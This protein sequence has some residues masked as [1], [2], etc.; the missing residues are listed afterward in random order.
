M[1]RAS[2]GSIFKTGPQGPVSLVIR[3]PPA[4]CRRAGSA[5]INHSGVCRRPGLKSPV[6]AASSSDPPATATA[7]LEH[8]GVVVRGGFHC[9]TR[10]GLAGDAPYPVDELASY[11]FL[12]SSES[13]PRGVC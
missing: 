2:G 4:F 9:S 6:K 11:C 3:H 10:L 12:G 13:H 8:G 1:S 7:R 5:A